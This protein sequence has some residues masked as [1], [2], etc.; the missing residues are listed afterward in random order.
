MSAGSK[1][2]RI[3]RLVKEGLDHYG[4]GEIGRAILAWEEA[5]ILDPNCTEATDYLKTADRRAVP[6]PMKKGE[7]SRAVRAVVLKAR[8]L[9]ADSDF[10]GALDLLGSAAK[11]DPLSLEVQAGIE[12]VRS[13]L[14][15]RL[16]DE[17]GGLAA[18]P[19]KKAQEEELKKLDLTSDAGFMLSMVDGS[20]SVTDLIS[21]SGLDAFQALRALRTLIEAGAV[22]MER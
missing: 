3:A 9:T 6:R 4:A 8:Q 5:L 18:V 17:V 21:A 19:V 15:R 16:R 11:A 7:T 10:E 12:L 2:D 22:G 14:F 20:T 1:E 13:H